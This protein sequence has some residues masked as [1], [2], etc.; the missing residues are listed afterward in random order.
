MHSTGSGRSLSDSLLLKLATDLQRTHRDSPYKHSPAAFVRDCLRFPAG[1]EMTFYQEDILERF[2]VHK[3]IAVRGPHG[4]GKTALASWVVLWGVLTADDVKV[5]TT[6]SA[7]RQLTKFLWPEIHKWA[8]RLRW[9]VLDREPF[10]KFELQV[11][12]LKL[13]A[14]QEAFAVASDNPALIEGA[15]AK[16]IVY[17]FDEAKAIPDATWDAAEGAFSTAGIESGDEAYALAISTP[18]EPQ[19]RFYDI[20]RRKPGLDDWTAIHVTL[21]DAIRAQ[22]IGAEWASL[23]KEQW[24][25]QT[26]VYQN[27]VL[28]EF[29]SADEDTVIPLAWVE[30]AMQRWS[31]N[32]WDEGERIWAIDPGVFVC[33]GVDV[34]MTSDKTVL[35]L[36]FGNTITELRKYAKSDLMQTTNVVTGVLDAYSTS[37]QPA[38]VDGI[39]IGA[40]VVSRLKELKRPVVAFIAS[41]T[42]DIKMRR[43]KSGELGFVN[44]RSAAW[45]NMREMLDPS[46][47]LDIALPPDELLIGELTAPHWV[48]QSGARIQVES[49]DDIRKRLNRST[50]SADAVIQAFWK[51]AK[52][53]R[54]R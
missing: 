6:A 5:P 19:G 37:K 32:R 11:Q 14:I 25:E 3:R 22:R 12:N 28:G 33:V 42:K 40:G 1:E 7:W 23:R 16:R 47:G 48:V 24:G 38:I 10:T 34:G 54:F 53:V 52:G 29:A 20:H 35:A 45:W 51:E 30:R 8:G 31:D 18:G 49:K 43:D 26:A 21:A 44:K 4:L 17:V 41:E 36:R 46:S 2:A 39:G 27:R 9:D 15:H 13:S 50:D